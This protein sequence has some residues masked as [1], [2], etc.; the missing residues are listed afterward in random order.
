MKSDFARARGHLEQAREIIANQ[1]IAESDVTV[2]ECCI[3]LDLLIEALLSI[4]YAR[5]AEPAAVLPFRPK[6]RTRRSD[7]T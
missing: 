7:K 1:K 5:P 6:G 2:S 4:E 3:A